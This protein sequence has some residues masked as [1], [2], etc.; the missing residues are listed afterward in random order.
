LIEDG[1]EQEFVEKLNQ[2]IEN[3]NLRI[4]MGQN[5]KESAAKY[6]IES[7][8]HSWDA[9]FTSIHLNKTV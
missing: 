2:L 1:N 6:T 5:A 8:M 4:E 9:L 3:E 7:I